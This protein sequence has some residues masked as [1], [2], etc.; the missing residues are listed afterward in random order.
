[1][2][3]PTGGILSTVFTGSDISLQEPSSDFIF[4]SQTNCNYYV[5]YAP[6]FIHIQL[7]LGH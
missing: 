2:K 3:L 6:I 1:M 7:S 5:F 4:I